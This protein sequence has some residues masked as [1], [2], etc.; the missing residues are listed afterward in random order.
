MEITFTPGFTEKASE[1]L[2]AKTQ[3]DVK[4]FSW[5]FLT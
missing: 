2:D 3:K 1:L 4:E 5:K